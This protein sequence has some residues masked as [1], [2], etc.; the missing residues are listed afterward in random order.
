[1]PKTFGF[2]L[3]DPQFRGDNKPERWRGLPTAASMA[4]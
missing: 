3:D 4:I 2:A 1:M